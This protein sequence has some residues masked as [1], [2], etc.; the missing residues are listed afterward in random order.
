MALLSETLLTSI[1]TVPDA[2]M[3]DDSMINEL[4]NLISYMILHFKNSL[5][6][7]KEFDMTI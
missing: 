4:D 6:A 7:I 3:R 1:W 5:D 2:F